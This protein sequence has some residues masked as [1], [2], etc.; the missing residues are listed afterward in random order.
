[1]QLFPKLLERFPLIWT[2]SVQRIFR[3]AEYVEI[4]LDVVSTACGSGSVGFQ[5][6][7]QLQ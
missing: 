2:H 6:Q 7:H 1:M 3:S 4:R 5:G